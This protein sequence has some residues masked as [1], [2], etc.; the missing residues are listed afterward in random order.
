MHYSLKFPAV[1]LNF[2]QLPKYSSGFL[3]RDTEE[4]HRYIKQI[5]YYDE[6]KNI[7]GE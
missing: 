6:W 4:Y 3:P 2:F 5:A 7:R 1:L